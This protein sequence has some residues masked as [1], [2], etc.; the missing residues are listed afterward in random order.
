MKPV[1]GANKF[2]DH[3]SRRCNVHLFL[4][5]PV[6]DDASLI[7]LEWYCESPPFWPPNSKPC[8]AVLSH[9]SVRLCA[10]LWTAAFQ[11]PL[12]MG[13]SRQEYWSGLP[14]SPPGDLSDPGAEHAA[15]A[16]PALQVYS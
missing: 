8:R 10:T 16:P 14:C 15:P 4:L 6:I 1:P 2:G 7:D 3:Y 5:G 13:F 11:A 9:F 12:S